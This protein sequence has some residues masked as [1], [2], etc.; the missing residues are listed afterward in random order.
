MCCKKC[1]LQKAALSELTSFRRVYTLNDGAQ[2]LCVVAR[3]EDEA[4]PAVSVTLTSDSPIDLVLHWGVGKGKKREWTAPPVAVQP[5][6]TLAHAG[7]AHSLS[8]LVRQF[9]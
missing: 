1:V 3:S 5:T 2:L 8:S 6:G 4:T 9:C 7:G